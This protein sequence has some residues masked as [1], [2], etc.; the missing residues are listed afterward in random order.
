MTYNINTY[1]LTGKLK[2]QALELS[3]FIEKENEA[4]PI[5]LD[6]IWG[7]IKKESDKRSQRILEKVKRLF[8]ETLKALGYDEP[9]VIV[10]EDE[11]GCPR[12]YAVPPS[13]HITDNHENP[14]IIMFYRQ[15]YTG[16]SFIPAA[17][18]EVSVGDISGDFGYVSYKEDSLNESS[19]LQ[20][21]EKGVALP[22]DFKPSIQNNE[23]ETRLK[24]FM[25]AGRSKA[26]V[27]DY[28]RS[29][30]NYDN[31][32]KTL[33][34]RTAKILD[35][36]I[37]EKESDIRAVFS[38]REDGEKNM[39][40]NIFDDNQSKDVVI[41]TND[42]FLIESCGKSSVQITP[43]PYTQEGQD[44]KRYFDSVPSKEPNINTY[45]Q[46]INPTAPP[47]GLSASFNYSYKHPALDHIDGVDYLVYHV[48]TDTNKADYC[49]PPDGI[50]INPDE[51]IWRSKDA[52]DRNNGITPPPAPEALSY[53]NVTRKAAP[54]T[55]ESP[56]P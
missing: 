13:F 19:L 17:A 48:D 50:A 32:V 36:L 43:N 2:A 20:V 39:Y 56:K 7:D 44:F 34:A 4:N 9:S 41:S 29:K 6:G 42:H 40:L 26:V 38:H 52:T 24:V 27:D 3:A 14:E 45:W 51:Y 18:E 46:L 54:P 23:K 12:A 49:C 5:Q 25:P 31:A 53:L 37:E 15:D 21:K 33:E 28:L 11:E 1:R 8:P 16:Q 35:L 47:T 10:N 22:A 55:L 30:K